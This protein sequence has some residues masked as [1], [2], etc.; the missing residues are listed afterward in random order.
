MVDLTL[1]R[2]GEVDK[3]VAALTGQPLV[4][5]LTPEPPHLRVVLTDEQMASKLLSLLVARGVNVEEAK[6]QTRSLEDVYLE[7]MKEA[8]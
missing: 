4:K 5:S 6:R 3:A 8:K 2:A 7:V 1:A